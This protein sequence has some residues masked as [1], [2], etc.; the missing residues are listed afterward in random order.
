[1]PIIGVS[2]TKETPF[3]LST[4]EFS[5]VYFYNNHTG[6]VPD[7]S[8]A[9]AIIDAVVAFEKSIH[10][11]LAT[12][13]YGRL[14]WQTLTE[15]GTT[16]LAQKPLSGTGGSSIVGSF[17]K[18]RAFLFRWPAGQDSRGNP[19]YLRKWYHTCG[20]FGAQ[21]SNPTT[22]VLENVAAIAS[23]SR[24]AMAS[25]VAE[26]AVLAA[27]GGG[28]ELCAK[29]GRAPTT[30]TPTCHEFLEHRQLGDMWRGG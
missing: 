25:K 27:A 13:I 23:A 29:S 14:W 26:V 22:T 18:E 7:A 6:S 20:G 15:P 11:S 1:M 28:W 16:M 19:V 2:I 30:F 8:G 12:F 10:A 4:Q 5:N 17:D 9:N 3:R 21:Y 24:T